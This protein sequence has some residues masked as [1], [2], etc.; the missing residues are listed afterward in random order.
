MAFNLTA[1]NDE[2]VVQGQL[3][4]AGQATVK[5]K[6]DLPGLITFQERSYALLDN[7]LMNSLP[8]IEVGDP[9]PKFLSRNEAPIRFNIKSDDTDTNF[10]GDTLR[11]TDTLAIWMQAGDVFEVP[12]LFCDSDGATYT[13]DKYDG[14]F[15]PETVIVESVVLSGASANVANVFVK[16]GNGLNTTAPA[17]AVVSTILSEYKL[18]KMQNTISDGGNAPNPVDFEPFSTQN[19]AQFFARTWGETSVQGQMNVYGK[20]TLEMKAVRSRREFFREVELALFWGRKNKTTDAG[21]LRYTTGGVVEFVPGASAS[22][23]GDTRLIDFG[24]AYDPE[25]Q[26]EI[27]EIVYR[28]GNAARRKDW[29]VGGQYLTVLYN[30]LEKFITVNDQF[31]RKYGWQVMELQLGHGTA[32]LHRHPMFTD[33]NTT[34]TGGVAYAKDAIIT[35]LDYLNLMYMKGHLPQVKQN[36]QP[37]RAFKRED[38]IFC[39]KGLYRRFPDAHAVIFN[40]TA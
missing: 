31:S 23:D 16:R 8:R 32:L 26:R 30:A 33:L 12:N 25:R 15:T 7:I 6:F 29:F 27:D 36:V 5:R 13:T 10:E 1:G 40:I 4:I 9:E 22:L 28:Y 17:G 34:G 39:M 37:N 35:D 38:T 18:I 19:F 2:F 24:G 3:G 14:G 20:E 11:I 21:A